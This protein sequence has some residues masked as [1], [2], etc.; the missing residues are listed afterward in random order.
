MKSLKASR[1]IKIRPMKLNDIKSFNNSE[2]YKFSSRGI[3]VEKDG[4]I[5]AIAGVLHTSPLQVFSSM[6][7]DMRK[8]P[9]T[10][11]KT[12]KKLVGIMNTYE[13]DLYAVAS[14]DES[15]SEKFLEHLGFDFIGVNN[16]GRYYKWAK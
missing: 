5:L 10:I 11:M 3:A 6:T 4:N 8:Y 15:N 14:E 7:D 16:S 9:I 1:K 12:A 2:N 13:Q